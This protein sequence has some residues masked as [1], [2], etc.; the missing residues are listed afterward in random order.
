M[1]VV[2]LSLVDRCT[3][4]R[5]NVVLA[6][7]TQE[8]FELCF[9][10]AVLCAYRSFV[11]RHCSA[12][13]VTFCFLS[14]LDRQHH[15]TNSSLPRRGRHAF[16]S[17]THPNGRQ[18]CH[19]PSS[20]SSLKLLALISKLLIY[21]LLS[22]QYFLYSIYPPVSNTCSSLFSISLTAERSSER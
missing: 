16:S 6:R 3:P 22:S 12:P 21:V 15:V 5:F 17:P 7:A 2:I 8:E 11:H 20:S 19:A 18:I 1:C 13:G 9:F 4:S 10:F 14:V